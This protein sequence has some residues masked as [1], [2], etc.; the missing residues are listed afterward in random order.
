[1]IKWSLFRGAIAAAALSLAARGEPPPLA[2]PTSFGV[3][4]HGGSLYP[5]DFPRM[6]KAGFTWVRT[7]L[8]WNFVERSKGVYDFG[9][10]D[11]LC[12]NLQANGIRPMV[13][14]DYGNHLYA[15]RGDTSPFLSRVNTD[16]FHAA[17]A[18]YCAAAVAHFA[19]RGFI[20]E[21]WNEPNN[22][23]AWAPKPNVDD[24]IAAMKAAAG[25]IRKRFPNEILIGPAVSGL[26]LDFIEACFRGGMLDYWSAVSVHPYRRNDPPSAGKDFARLRALI[27]RY[28][29][30]SRTVPIVAGEWGY[31]TTWSGVSDLKQ[32]DDVSQMVAFCRS[33]NVPVAIWYDWRDDGDDPANEENRFGLNRRA[34]GGLFE[35]KPGYFAAMRAIT[36]SPNGAN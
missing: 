12:N 2:G 1:M 11:R 26:D 9:S 3:N 17:Y 27:A 21:Q 31:S 19:G 5:G 14:L 36:G 32:A 24:Y 6:H 22:R 35:P 20:W 10:F 18:A 16:E 13:I 25:A 4:I 29:P 28:A 23:H 15:N 34:A 7:D 8:L 30:P 33:E